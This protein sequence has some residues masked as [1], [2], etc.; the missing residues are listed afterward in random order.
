[1]S[2]RYARQLGT[3]RHLHANGRLWTVERANGDRTLGEVVNGA[4]FPGMWFGQPRLGFSS[5][6]LAG[7]WRRRALTERNATY[8]IEFKRRCFE[9][10][11]HSRTMRVTHERLTEAREVYR[12]A[13]E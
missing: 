11:Q 13:A 10:I 4:F 3:A 5:L 9:G 1:M 6:D 8:R 2:T 12:I 7:Y